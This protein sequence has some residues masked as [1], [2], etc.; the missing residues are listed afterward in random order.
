MYLLLNCMHYGLG[1]YFVKCVNC[2]YGNVLG[3]DKEENT[4][5]IGIFV[6]YISCRKLKPTGL[7]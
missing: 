3:I 7:L 6:L 4:L 2:L 5:L 1:K